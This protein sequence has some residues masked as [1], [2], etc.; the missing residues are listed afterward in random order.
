MTVAAYPIVRSET[1]TLRRVLAGASLARYGDG[2]FKLCDADRSIKSQAFNPVLAK[3]LR[4]ILVDSGACMV[5][6]PNLNPDSLARMTDE[7]RRFWE[8]Y[9]SAAALLAPRP[10]ASAF[11]TRPDSAPAI[12]TASYWDQ[13]EELWRGK[14]VTLVRGST[15]SFTAEDLVGAGVVREVICPRQ[16]AFVEYAQILE[17]IGR[18]KRALLCLGPT[19]TILAVDLCA[20]GVHAVDVGHLG[21]F[22]R[23]HQRGDPMWV[24]KADRVAV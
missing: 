10:Y 16:H 1:E 6:I 9:R 11:I 21:M 23:K 24:T 17:R 5:G 20:R 22:W 18:P 3:R 12:D 4:E 15:K 14:D 8:P 13:I 7:K 19:A 2:E